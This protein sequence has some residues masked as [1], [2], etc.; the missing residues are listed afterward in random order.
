M[1]KI[2]VIEKVKYPKGKRGKVRM[3]EN[4]YPLKFV[5]LGSCRYSKNYS[6]KHFS[7]K[8]LINFEIIIIIVFLT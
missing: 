8:S 4:S 7:I 6:V 3:T 1:D 2:E 5:E